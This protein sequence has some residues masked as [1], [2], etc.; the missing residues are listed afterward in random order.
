MPQTN[1]SVVFHI[2]PETLKNIAPFYGIDPKSINSQTP[3][4][5]QIIANFD[6]EKQTF[7]VTKI[8]GDFYQARIKDEDTA[9]TLQDIIRA[10]KRTTLSYHTNKTFKEQYPYFTSAANIDLIDQLRQKGIISEAFDNQLSCP[11]KELFE[12]VD[13]YKEKLSLGREKY[14]AQKQEQKFKPDE[15]ISPASIEIKAPPASDKKEQTLFD[16]QTLLKRKIDKY[17]FKASQRNYPQNIFRRY[18]AM[19]MLDYIANDLTSV[20]GLVQH[21]TGHLTATIANHTK[22]HQSSWFGFLHRLHKP[23]LADVYQ[24]VLDFL[25][26]TAPQTFEETTARK[27]KL[28]IDLS[29]SAIIKGP[30]FKRVPIDIADREK[31]LET[32]LLLA[33]EEWVQK[34]TPS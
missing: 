21:L 11:S 34:H 24:D 32:E 22:I 12:C 10:E 20:E 31:R 6:E 1:F 17:M 18:S 33:D 4:K 13:Y 14:I 15:K 26:K 29:V 19:L 25:K 27:D 28:P 7:S 8:R 16:A 2:E 23:A 3:L 30:L 5:L 9:I